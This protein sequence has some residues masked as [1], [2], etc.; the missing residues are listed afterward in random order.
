MFSPYQKRF[1]QGV[2]VNLNVDLSPLAV[3]FRPI[4]PLSRLFPGRFSAV[5]SQRVKPPTGRYRHPAD[6]RDFLAL[7]SACSPDLGWLL[8]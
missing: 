8:V 4:H 3:N 6:Q 2:V 5:L 1:T 7:A